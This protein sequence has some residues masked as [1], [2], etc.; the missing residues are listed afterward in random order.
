MPLE[1]SKEKEWMKVEP[2][3]RGREGERTKSRGLTS[4]PMHLCR[5]SVIFSSS[6]P[7]GNREKAMAE[8]SNVVAK[9]L[10]QSGYNIKSITMTYIINDN[11][12][13]T[14]FTQDKN[15]TLLPLA[16]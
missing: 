2:K 12:G 6:A 16:A 14:L 5:F 1:P 3:S 9:A 11:T 10:A 15:H 13:T 7:I 8:L 4:V